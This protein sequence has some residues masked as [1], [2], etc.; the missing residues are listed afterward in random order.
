[1]PGTVENGEEP[2]G[3]QGPRLTAISRRGGALEGSDR[4][5]TRAWRS[6][7]IIVKEETAERLTPSAFYTVVWDACKGRPAP[8]RGVGRSRILHSMALS[9]ETERS[10]RDQPWRHLSRFQTNCEQYFPN[11]VTDVRLHAF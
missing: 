4:S 11:W 8:A 10:G 7:A 5:V 1:M 9:D 2:Q 3:C 6:L